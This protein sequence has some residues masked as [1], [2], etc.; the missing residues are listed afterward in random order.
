MRSEDRWFGISLAVFVIAAA[1]WI[2]VALFNSVDLDSGQAGF[3]R[4]ALLLGL[5][6][7]LGFGA[8]HFL[9]GDK[10]FAIFLAALLLGAVV[11][12]VVALLGAELS[13]G[14]MTLV[15]YGVLLGLAA[16]AGF[17]AAGFFGED[18]GVGVFLGSVIAGAAV[19]ILIALFDAVSLSTQGRAN[20]G[21]VLFIGT[22]AA[23]GLGLVAWKD[24]REKSSAR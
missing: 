6:G 20:F 9:G 24:A 18:K 21:Y 14:Q 15:R 12:I 17:I 10:G 19:W 2:V 4:Y 8:A 16:L 3:L 1:I 5:A 23:I 22:P 11:W 13:P 7:L